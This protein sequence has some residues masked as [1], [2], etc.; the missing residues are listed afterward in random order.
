MD[1]RRVT[2][3]DVAAEANVSVASVSLYLNNRPGLADTTRQRIAEAVGR[4]GYVPR[5]PVGT[6]TE[7]SFLGLLVERLPLSAFSDMFYGE[8]IHGMEQRAR[9]LGYNIALMVIE[10]GGGLPRLLTSGARSLAG[11]VMLGGGDINRELIN[12]VIQQGYPALLV[13]NCP[14]DLRIECVS[15]DYV[16]GAYHM[17][18]YL[19]NRGHR[20]IA[21][22]QGPSKYPS[23][24]E[25]F[26]GY[27]CGLIENGIPVD[28]ALIQP[29]L[30]SGVHNK[31]Y[32]EMKALLE[33]R[34]TFDAVF[35]TTDRTA[36]GALQALQEAGIRVPGDIALAGFDNVSES[37][38]TLPPLTTVNVPKREMGDLA[39][40]RL[41]DLVTRSSPSLPVKTLLH[42]SLVVRES[43]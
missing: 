15:P 30:S 25:R 4:V 27:C 24:V 7:H 20:R 14:G 6:N 34:E 31:G 13:D 16:A 17:T 35:C 43:A 26:R 11:V 41:H 10:P 1:T 28:P 38:H 21:F 3:R 39:C 42:T 32:R 40:L 19:L 2:I 33:R 29:P 18:Q 5:R 23:L 22:I 8:L 36:L 9:V 12:E 37:S